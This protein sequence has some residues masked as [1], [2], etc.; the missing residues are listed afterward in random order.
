M[1]IDHESLPAAAAITNSSNPFRYSTQSSSP[2]SMSSS[3]SPPPPSSLT[4]ASMPIEHQWPIL[5]LSVFVLVGCVGNLMV[6]LAIRLDP[7]L[8]NQTNY[9]LFSLATVDFLVSGLVMP[10]AIAK[11]FFTVW[12]LGELVCTLWVFLDV[13]LC[14]TSILLLCIISCERYFAINEPLK[15][16]DK[17]KSRAMFIIAST[18]LLSAFLSSPILLLS[19]WDAQNVLLGGQCG[20]HNFYFILY[21]STFSF[22]IPLLVMITMY[23]LTVRKLRQVLKQFAIDDSDQSGLQ[24]I[25]L[26]TNSKLRRLKTQMSRPANSTQSAKPVQAEENHSSLLIRSRDSC[27]PSPSQSRQIGWKF[28]R[29]ELN[30][31]KAIPVK[32]AKKHLNTQQASNLSKSVQSLRLNDLGPVANVKAVRSMNELPIGRSTSPC[33]SKEGLKAADVGAA[34]GDRFKRLV[35]KQRLVHRAVNAFKKNGESAAVKNE[36]KAVKV[37]GIVFVVFVIAWIPFAVFNIVFA[38]FP[39]YPARSIMNTLTWLGYIS[40]VLN[41]FIYNAFNERFRLTFKRLVR[42][43]PGSLKQNR[44]HAKFSSCRAGKNLLFKV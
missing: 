7:K 15:T 31:R 36:Q 27:S 5:L 1:N 2:L 9:F 11:S 38:L 16:R 10:L 41:P 25:V 43:N 22:G 44:D 4:I 3:L 35:N 42:C 30:E 17:S 28:I 37:L 33:S 32:S 8:Q 21:A 34:T 20:I 12:V 24:A 6:C 26:A 40:S 13:F 14:T 18:W 23:I 19:I 39:V 29:S